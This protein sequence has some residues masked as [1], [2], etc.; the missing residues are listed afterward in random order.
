MRQT[1]ERAEAPA[2]IELEIYDPDALP[3]AYF[4]EHHKVEMRPDRRRILLALLREE[5]VP[6]CRLV[7]PG[8]PAARR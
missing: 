3:I 5:V 6:G 1:S 7:E 8:M 4:R 2:T